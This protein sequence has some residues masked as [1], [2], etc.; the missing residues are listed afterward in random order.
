[1]RDRAVARM[2]IEAD[3]KK[4][5]DAQEF[6]LH[7]QPK[8]DLESRKANGGAAAVAYVIEAWLRDLTR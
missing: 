1:M 7:Y 6:V 8:V 3:L 5:I 2:E 4:A